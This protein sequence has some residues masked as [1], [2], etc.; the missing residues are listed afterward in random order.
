MYLKASDLFNLR[1]E[2]LWSKVILTT[3]TIIYHQGVGYHHF[4]QLPRNPHH[5]LC[6]HVSFKYS[7]VILWPKKLA[8]VS[9]MNTKIEKTW[10]SFTNLQLRKKFLLKN[11]KNPSKLKLQPESLLF[12][13]AAFLPTKTWFQVPLV[14]M[15]FS[16]R[17]VAASCASNSSTKWME[18]VC[19][20]G[21]LVEI[22]IDFFCMESLK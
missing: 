18:S 2:V 13:I 5:V 19:F 22:A 21:R 17:C 3:Q 4:Y 16:C 7:C 10:Q 8:E 11:R 12:P 9:S 1:L 20:N 6:R 14:C 15:T